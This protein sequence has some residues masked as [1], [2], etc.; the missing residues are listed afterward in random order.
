MSR[1]ERGAE[2]LRRDIYMNPNYKWAHNNLGVIYDKLATLASYWGKSEE[3]QDYEEKARRH[4]EIALEIDPEQIFALFNLGSGSLR[5]GRRLIG[6]GKT[7]EAA[8]WLDQARDL[9]WRA[10]D[11]QPHREDCYENLADIARIENDHVALVRAREAYLAMMKRHKWAVD[12]E[13]PYMELGLGYLNA[14][15]PIP[16]NEAARPEGPLGPEAPALN[17]VERGERAREV[18]LLAR[19]IVSQKMKN[20]NLTE[21]TRREFQERSERIGRLLAHASLLLGDSEEAAE[22]YGELLERGAKDPGTYHEVIRILW[23]AG[24]IARAREYL[25]KAFGDPDIREKLYFRILADPALKEIQEA[26]WFIELR[27]L[28]ELPGLPAEPGEAAAPVPKA[29]T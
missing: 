15:Q 28:Y 4:Y 22:E 2:V 5:Q 11:V 12:S 25:E 21:K 18:L 23:S 16:A 29:G 3:A 17:P 9:M 26:P 20:P 24:E 1:F 10:I 27:D 13:M 8:T 6:E 7:D 14:E 19:R